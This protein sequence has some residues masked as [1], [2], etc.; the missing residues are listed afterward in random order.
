MTQR[1]Y[2]FVLGRNPGLSLLEID[3]ALSSAVSLA[4]ASLAIAVANGSL[5][6]ARLAL[7]RLGG[8]IKIGFC[9]AEVDTMPLTSKVCVKS[10]T[11]WIA[12]TCSNDKKLTLGLSVYSLA[13]HAKLTYGT[14]DIQSL[15]ISIKK[16]LREKG[17]SVRVV[18]P[19]KGIALT[20]VQVAKNKLTERPCMEVV[21]IVDGENIQIGI[22]QAVQEFESYSYR[23]WQRP[24]KEA[25]RGMLPPKLAQIMINLAARGV[26]SDAKILDPFCGSGT[27]TQEALLMGYENAHA[28]DNDPKAVEQT[29]KNLDWLFGKKK[30]EQ[31]LLILADAARLNEYYPAHS[32]DAIVTEP[33][34]GP[35]YTKPPKEHALRKTIHELG[36]LYRAFL[37][38]AKTVL[39]ESGRVCMVWPVWILFGEHV[40]LPLESELTELGFHNVTIPEDF[41][42][43]IPERTARDTILVA[44]PDSVVARELIVLEPRR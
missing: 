25:A 2:F 20:S 38:K 41:P 17:Y 39:K 28:S 19:Q 26:T 22:T 21:L 33:Y 5:D 37:K 35:L 34:L 14:R 30:N 18:L 44:R 4:S 31:S 6:D 23:D 32:F 27:V 24:S 15:G 11:D 36:I 42:F 16:E 1:K 8:T 7:S 9:A 40:F 10:I 3:A 12:R 43:P 13:R 29:Q